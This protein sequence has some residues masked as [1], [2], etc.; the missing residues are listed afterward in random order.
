MSEIICPYC[1][2]SIPEDSI[3]CPFCTTKL[4]KDDYSKML[5]P[6][7]TV[8]AIIWIIANLTGLVLIAYHPQVL[9]MRDKDG[10]LMFS[11]YEYTAMCLKPMILVIAPFIIA[12][13]KNYK[14]K[15]AITG[16]SIS[17]LFAILFISYFIHLSK[18][19][20]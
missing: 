20:S 9:T 14:V 10:V 11:I 16:L 19:A 7:G 6:V 2:Q 1:K 8:I 13:I 12:I 5:L 3:V 15:N 18:M 4:K 17:I